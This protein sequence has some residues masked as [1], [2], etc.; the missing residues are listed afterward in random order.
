MR[1]SGP[2][3]SRGGPCAKVTEKVL[4]TAAGGLKPGFLSADRLG[5]ARDSQKC[6][7]DSSAERRGSGN[8]FPPHMHITA[9]YNRITPREEAL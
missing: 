4:N 1:R 5:E 7:E 2:C 6:Q 9:M 3:R 8:G